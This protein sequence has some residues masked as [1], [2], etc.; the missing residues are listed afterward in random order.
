[1]KIDLHTHYLPQAY[2]QALRK[3]CGEYPDGFPTPDWS[4]EQHLEAMNRL[5]IAV[6]ML[7][8]SSP[9]IHFGDKKITKD[10]ARTANENGAELVGK[11]P[12]KFGLLASLPLP[13]AEDSIAEI[14]YAADI[15]R[16]DGF[17]VPTNTLGVYLGNPCLNAV[18]EELNRRK[19]VVALHP[20][21]PAL[22]PEHVVEGLPVPMME[23]LFDTT[24]TVVNLII[25]GALSRFSDITFI[26]PH[27]GAF[28]PVLADRLAPALQLM[29]SVFGDHIGGEAPDIYAAL[30][31]LYYDLAGAC[32]P[33]QLANLMQ[34]V[35]T[36][37]FV[38]GS[39][40]P[41]TPDFACESL[42]GALD[43]TELL[44]RGDRR[45]IYTNN[46][47]RLFP[48]LAAR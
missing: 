45:L 22:V 4:P 47:L 10:L 38:Y 5:G 26:I 15:L 27:A 35:G 37:H 42:A 16:A 9:H 19:S 21:K 41:Y 12:G 25:T 48:R 6:S 2:K 8:L 31:G 34:I 44:T 11:Y 18:F 3:Y 39:D 24:R 14:Q 1:M 30:Q 33:R 20:N 17:T 40:Y 32:L 13:D 43:T 28:L 23:F 29:P 36:D 46:A 7:S